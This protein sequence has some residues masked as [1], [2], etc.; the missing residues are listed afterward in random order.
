MKEEFTFSVKQ[1]R[2]K[3]F[4]HLTDMEKLA[5]LSQGKVSIQPSADGRQHVF[6]SEFPGMQ[7]VVCRT[8]EWE[9]PRICVRAFDI[10]DLPTKLSMRFEEEGTGTRITLA[11]EMT[12]QSMV[13]KMLLPMLEQ[14]LNKEREKA[15][16][17]L[18]GQLD[19]A[20]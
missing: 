16:S 19:A 17:R 10:K 4:A 6:K 14:Q 8:T 12:A 5:E 3:V 13:Y 9:P 15:L 7:E 2:D 18:R 1:P 20:A 11:V